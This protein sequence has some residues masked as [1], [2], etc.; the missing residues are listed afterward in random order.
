MALDF[1]T[2]LSSVIES[3]HFT[4]FFTDFDVTF[5]VMA[6]FHPFQPIFF[7]ILAIE[8]P[9]YYKESWNDCSDHSATAAALVA[10]VLAVSSA[11]ANLALIRDSP[12]STSGTFDFPKTTTRLFLYI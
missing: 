6:L 4:I 10:Y 2:N 1:L 7:R 5:R 11:V 3:F 12:I 8:D 9:K